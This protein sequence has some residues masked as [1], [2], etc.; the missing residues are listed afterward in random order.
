MNYHH[1]GSSIMRI[2]LTAACLLTSSAFGQW[3]QCTGPYGGTINALL[4]DSALLYAATDNGAVF[5]SVN[6]GALWQYRSEGIGAGVSSVQALLKTTGYLF[7][8]GAGGMYRSADSGATWAEA[9]SGLSS[10]Q[11]VTALCA[12]DSFLYAGTGGNRIY[13][14]TDRG[15]HWARSDSG[16]DSSGQGVRSII[17][18][19]NRVFA[20]VHSAGIYCSDSAG[21]AWTKVNAGLA[22]LQ[23]W[24]LLPWNG[25]LFAATSIGVYRSDD[26]GAVW[27]RLD[28]SWSS[29]VYTLAAGSGSVFAGTLDGVY[30]STDSG[31]HFNWSNAVGFRPV[32]SIASFGAKTWLGTYWDGVWYNGGTGTWGEA[33]NGLTGI[34]VLSLASDPGAVFAGIEYGVARSTDQGATWTRAAAPIPNGVAFVAM[35]AGAAGAFGGCYYGLYRS[36]NN[37]AAWQNM[38]GGLPDKNI[39][40]LAI[41]LGWTF[42]GT[43]DGYLLRSAD[44]GATWTGSDSGLPPQGIKSVLVDGQT[45]WAG[46]AAGVYRS[47]DSGRTWGVADDGITVPLNTYS[48]IKRKDM[49]YAGTFSQAVLRAADTD[50]VVWK[51]VDTNWTDFVPALAIKDTVLYAA[52][53]LGVAASNDGTYWSACGT[54]LENTP[55][56]SLSVLGGGLLAGTLK[57]GIWFNAFPA[58]HAARVSPKVINGITFIRRVADR[59]YIDNHGADEA[60]VSVVKADGRQVMSCAIKKDGSMMLPD[61]S[62]SGHAHGVY[63]V[64]IKVRGACVEAQK[65]VVP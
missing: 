40:S 19:G 45:L 59:I 62:K 56:Y 25:Y 63:F 61:F 54:G 51:R 41:G 43:G 7:A 31:V 65:V 42:A 64:S 10:D 18:Y 50:T 49:L 58:V 16:M 3:T 11:M 47:A 21:T 8:A 60:R 27:K 52:T 57:R 38:S 6:N 36:V 1:A 28:S 15:A 26:S 13:R 32:K 20:S 29:I 12:T 46:T 55:V 24:C 17:V 2:V 34:P 14:S 4:C 44:T 30:V 5:R 23:V 53:T 39:Q 9:D 35:A 37:G 33:N 48:L 22:N